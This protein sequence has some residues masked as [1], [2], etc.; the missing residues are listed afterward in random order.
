MGVPVLGDIAAEVLE[1]WGKGR[2][3]AERRAEVEAVAKAAAAEVAAEVR[4]LLAELAAGLTAAQRSAVEGYLLQVPAAVRAALRRPA[5]PTGT[6]LPAGHSLGSIGDILPLLPSR[7]PRFRPGDRPAGVGDWELVELLGAGG[8]GEVWK[9]RNPHF[10]GVPPVALKFC[11]HPGARDRLLRHEAGVLNRVM[12]GGAHP[13]IA[14]LEHT[15]LGADPP[16]LAYEYVAG[17]DLA[18][19]VRER[20]AA[21]APLRPGEAASIVLRLA[22]AVGSAHRLSPPVVHRDLKPAN[23]LVRHL[24]GGGYE[25]KVTDFGIAALADGHGVGGSAPATGTTTAGLLG[26]HTPLYASPQQAAGRPPDPRDDVYALGVIWY[27]LLVGDLTRGRPGG[28][29]WQRRLADGGS[30]A[31]SVGLLASCLEDEL[32]DR[33]ADAAVMAEL[34]AEL[35]RPV[36]A[37]AR[38]AP[39]G[40]LHNG[41]E[42]DWPDVGPPTHA[43]SASW[44]AATPAEGGFW[45]AVKDW[46]QGALILLLLGAVGCVVVQSCT[47]GPSPPTSVAPPPAPAPTNDEV[48]V[49]AATEKIRL[50]P[51]SAAT[52][53]ERGRLYFRQRNHPLAVRDFNEAIRLDPKSA[54]AHAERCRSFGVLGDLDQAVRDAEEAVRLDPNLSGA[55]TARGATQE[56]RGDAGKALADYTQ[57]IRLDP[58]H[59]PAYFLRARV[60]TDP[61]KT[62]RDCTEAIRLDPKMAEAYYLRAV[63]LGKRGDQQAAERDLDE[64]IRLA[65]G[66]AH[67]HLT[68]GRVHLTEGRPDLAAASYERAIGLGTLAGPQ[69]DEARRCLEEA[70]RPRP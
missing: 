19:L 17:G 47:S 3:D 49:E 53:L 23:V 4:R 32:I 65:P 57:A 29:A 50:N 24:P 64:A 8:F 14:R 61:D 41:A 69:A 60:Q 11:T 63:R 52:H 66:A 2:R 36:A 39:A 68:R 28:A 21:G 43:A 55:Y 33:P 38:A 42:P 7:L 30:T 5:D 59:A 35:A 40:N 12:L 58:T 48:L 54:P 31:E 45:D 9:A 27:Q 34:L 20:A 10:D 44:P 22:E 1:A 18:A 56:T 13:G 15:Y 51:D 46:V 16:C 67:F 6:T 70:R 25:L 62:I 26:A 37:P